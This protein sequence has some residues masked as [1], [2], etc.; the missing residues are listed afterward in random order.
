LYNKN[1]NY[2]NYQN[3]E[4]SELESIYLAKMNEYHD[5]EASISDEEFD[6]LELILSERGSEVIIKVGG[7]KGALNH[8]TPMLS[9][10]KTHIKTSA[11]LSNIPLTDLYNTHWTIKL[12]GNAVNLIYENGIL[13]KAPTRGDGSA[14]FD[15]LDK[16]RPLVPSDIR[17]HFNT[18]IPQF[19]EIRGEV[20]MSKGAFEEWPDPS[21]KN[22]RNVLSGLLNKSDI[23]LP[24][25]VY[26]IALE[27]R[28][29]DGKDIQWFSEDHLIQWGFNKFVNPHIGDLPKSPS[30][31]DL[32]AIWEKGLDHR[33]NPDFPFVIDGL[34]YKTDI[35][36]RTLLGESKKAPLWA[37]ALKFPSVI[38]ETTVLDIQW[39]LTKLGQLY[40]TA[41]LAPVFLDGSVVQKAAVYTL[42]N[43]ITKQIF[44]GAIVQ[45][46]KGGDIIPVIN[47]VIKPS[48]TP[49]TYPTD[50]E[51][52]P[53]EKIGLHLV[54]PQFR[55]WVEQNS[56]SSLAKLH[57][58]NNLDHC[59]KTLSWKGLGPA[60]SEILSNLYIKD[61]LDL[62]S[63][64]IESLETNLGNSQYKILSGYLVSQK[65]PLESLI[66][67]LNIPNG[68]ETIS[69]VLAKI[70]LKQPVDL[71]YCNKEVLEAF[72]T[73]HYSNYL[74]NLLEKAKKAG[75]EIILP[76]V[77]NNIPLVY[78]GS[79][80]PLFKSK[81]HFNEWA[82]SKGYVEGK[83]KDARYLITDD[84]TKSSNK[85]DDAIKRNIPILTY[86]QFW[87][88]NQ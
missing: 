14:G 44:P 49:W 83:M 25:G 15:K 82:L 56:Q 21:K 36:H 2:M 79:P 35:I 10:G 34:V 71:K 63:Y 76:Q 78:T 28:Y 37:H 45:L 16:I 85:M 29:L 77:N 30:K 18:G 5:G 24:P 54:I 88:L 6:A 4:L 47:K 23:T 12:D 1:K 69:K 64:P 41:I 51:G 55:T 81:S 26:F 8:I 40:P 33:T 74:T 22:P 68:G 60:V 57:Y 50:W 75:W 66:N 59:F 7:S 17:S 52:A 11:D 32:D 42:D 27:A 72:Q 38:T 67:C 73:S 48:E 20:I 62:L 87:D 70:W 31:A 19:I 46:T 13:V 65:V 80:M 9:L 61:L 3:L 43:V 39:T 53:L 58:Q 84:L 86:Q